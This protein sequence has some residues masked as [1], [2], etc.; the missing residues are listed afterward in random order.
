MWL[1]HLIFCL[2]PKLNFPSKRQFSLKLFPRLIEK[3]SQQYVILALVACF[4]TTT[5]FDI[6]MSKG[7]YD[8]FALVIIFL[9][10]DWQ[11]KH[12]T[13]GLFEATQTTGQALA[14]SLTSYQANMVSGKRSSLMLKTKGQISMQ[15]L[16]HLKL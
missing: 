16:L 5:S 10:N 14:R 4:S 8:V 12:I 7:T 6:W 1:K 15:W 3:K 9:N 13:I 2:C 11:P